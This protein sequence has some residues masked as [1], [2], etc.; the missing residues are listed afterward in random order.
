MCV[1]NNNGYQI[2]MLYNGWSMVITGI[3][4]GWRCWIALA[5]KLI[6]C[7][8]MAALC[9]ASVKRGIKNIGANS[10]H[11]VPVCWHGKLTMIQSHHDQVV[12]F[13]E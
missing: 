13:L 9:A 10:L 6:A 3:W 1:E 7:A 4:P 8:I 2:P 11:S 12:P 5:D